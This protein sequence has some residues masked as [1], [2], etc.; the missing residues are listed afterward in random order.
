MAANLLPNSNAH[1]YSV[2]MSKPKYTRK[3]QRVSDLSNCNLIISQVFNKLMN[4]N[5]GC[6]CIDDE[7]SSAVY[8]MIDFLNNVREV[9][10]V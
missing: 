5:C 4:L 1:K 7:M 2:R 10:T 6:R 3:K 9:S 8:T